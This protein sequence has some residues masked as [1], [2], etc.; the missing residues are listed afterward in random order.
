MRL[1]VPVFGRPGPLTLAH[2]EIAARYLWTNLLPLPLV[3]AGLGVM[4]LQWW[5]LDR[6]A[7]WAAASVITWSLTLTT[8]HRFLND[9]KRSERIVHWTIAVCVTLLVSSTAFAGVAPAFWVAGDRLNNVLLYVVL[10]AGIASS[11]AQSAPS[12]PV[13]ATNITPYAVFFIGITLVNETY[14]TGLLMAFL[15]L[16][17]VGLVAMYARAV[18]QLA[19]DMLVLRED[20]EELI[21]KLRNAVADANAARER[22]E[23]AS[24]AKSEFLANM[25]HELRTPL[26][27]VLGFSEVIKDQMF[28]REAVDRYAD[29]ASNVHASGSHLLGLI[30]DILDLSKI[31]AGKW[32]LR[33]T[34]FSLKDACHEALRFIE[35]QAVQKSLNLSLDVPRDVILQADERAIRQVLINLLSNAVKFTPRNGSIAVALRTLSDGATQISVSDTGIGIAREDLTRV[36]ESFGQGQ[37]D[38]ATTD[39]RGTGLGLPIVKGLVQAHGGILRIESAVGKGTTVLIEFPSARVVRQSPV[40]LAAAS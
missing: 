30:N 25:S 33:E 19:R 11:G 35:P 13:V 4:L 8:L 23:R 20:K 1:S 7:L 32:N 26:N 10:G 12:V 28:G 17:Y 9:P 38:V 36:L 22:A 5:D 34:Q 3:I 16:C 29:Y 14:P 37:H 27:A 6:I 18:W 21:T 2:L 31:E 40:G 15:Q 24:A 39:E